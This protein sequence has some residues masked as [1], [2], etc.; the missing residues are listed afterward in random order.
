MSRPNLAPGAEGEGALGTA[1][2]LSALVV[3]SVFPTWFYCN[4]WAL[5]APL[6]DCAGGLGGVAQ[7][8]LGKSKNSVMS[9]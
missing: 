8:V 6:V 2:R 4:T 5:H 1:G 7:G 9:I 3:T